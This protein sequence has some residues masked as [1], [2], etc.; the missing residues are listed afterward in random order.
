MQSPIF[1]QDREIERF[2]TPL[3]AAI[4]VSSAVWTMQPTAQRSYGKLGDCEQFIN[5]LSKTFPCPFNI[6][7]VS[8]NWIISVS[9]YDLLTF[10]IMLRI[11]P[12]FGSF[13]IVP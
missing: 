6:A 12:S 9:L 1:L 5:T 10:P 3:Q 4:L 11:I 2:N 13:K 8:L 7:Y